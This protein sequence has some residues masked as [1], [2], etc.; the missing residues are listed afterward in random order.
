MADEWERRAAALFERISEQR[1]YREAKR[2]FAETVKGHRPPPGPTRRPPR[3]RKGQHHK[4]MHDAV[5]FASWDAYREHVADNKTEFARTLAENGAFRSR[6]FRLGSSMEQIRRRLN[7][8]LLSG[9][10]PKSLT[11]E[12]TGGKITAAKAFLNVVDR[13]KYRA[14]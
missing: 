11:M 14:K 6:V 9:S 1:G 10:T 4:P 7:K 13:Q 12:A 8:L 3:K 5:L 2:I